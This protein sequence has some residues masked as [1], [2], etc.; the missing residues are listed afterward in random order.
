MGEVI[1]IAV[2]RS[3][4]GYLTVGMVAGAVI[5]YVFF[6]VMVRL[7]QAQSATWYQETV[8]L[9]EIITQLEATVCSPTK[10]AFW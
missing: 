9:N 8:A 1:S 6:S 3:E 5:V 2:T 7:E 4:F 10:T